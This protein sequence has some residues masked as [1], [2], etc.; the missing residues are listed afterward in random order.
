MGFAVA[1][2]QVDAGTSSRLEYRNHLVACY[3]IVGHGEIEVSGRRHPVDPGTFYAMNDHEPT[4]L[5]A[6]TE[7]RIVSIFNPPIEGHERHS[8]SENS[9]S[10]Y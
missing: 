6:K 9:A 10:S 2:T 7:M 8:L 1:D 3:C 5:H 4:I